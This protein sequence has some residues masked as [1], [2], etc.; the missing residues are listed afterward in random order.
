MTNVDSRSRSTWTVLPVI[1]GIR[2]AIELNNGL[3]TP[4]PYSSSL[5]A[6]R[7]CSVPRAGQAPCGF[8]AEPGAVWEHLVDVV[9]VAVANVAA[10]GY[11]FP[12]LDKT[13]G[14]KSVRSVCRFSSYR[15]QSLFVASLSRAPIE[16]RGTVRGL[17]FVVP[18]PSSLTDVAGKDGPTQL[19]VWAR[20][21]FLFP[22][23]FYR[24]KIAKGEITKGT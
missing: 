21:I 4:T 17:S 18:R 10:E 6:H 2:I 22:P 14:F 9:V 24:D 1:K 20:S 5:R 8:S 23:F 11:G 7:A 3:A 19:L 15:S 13:V 12:S 16:Q